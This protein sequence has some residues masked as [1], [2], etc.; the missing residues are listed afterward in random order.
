MTIPI[1]PSTNVASFY[2]A[3]GY[4]KHH[5]LAQ[6]AGTSDDNDPLHA[7]AIQ[8]MDASLVSDD[9]EDNEPTEKWDWNEGW[10]ELDDDM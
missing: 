10:H 3:P 1:H 5:L 2:L 4:T 9:E 6:E 7:T 8:V